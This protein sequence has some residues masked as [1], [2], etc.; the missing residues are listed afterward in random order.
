MSQSGGNSSAQNGTSSDPFQRLS[1]FKTPRDLSL[2]GVK[3]NKKIFTPNLSVT[4]N[5]NKGQVIILYY[6]EWI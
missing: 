1:S 3:P 4:R 5:K 6:I 2:G